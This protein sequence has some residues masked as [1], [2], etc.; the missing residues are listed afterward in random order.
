MNQQKWTIDINTFGIYV[1]NICQTSEHGVEA[2]VYMYIY[3]EMW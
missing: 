1:W 2:M 3:N